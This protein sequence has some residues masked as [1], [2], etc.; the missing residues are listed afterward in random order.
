MLDGTIVPSIKLVRDNGPKL[1]LLGTALNIFSTS[2]PKQFIARE[3][4]A[5][6]EPLRLAR[7]EPRPPV[8]LILTMRSYRPYLRG[9]NTRS[10]FTCWHHKLVLPKC[11]GR[12]DLS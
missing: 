7:Q 4:E 2:L 11:H 10:H 1:L 6:A 9:P 5:P 12:R 8:G 3:G